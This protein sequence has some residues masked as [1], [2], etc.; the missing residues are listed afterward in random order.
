MRILH[1]SNNYTPYAGGLVSSLNALLPGL[2]EAGHT[3]MLIV[4][5]FVKEHNDPSFVRRI[6]AFIRFSYYN[7]PCSLFLRPSAHIDTLV[8]QF[9]P[10]IIHVHHP[11]LLGFIGGKIARRYNIPCVFT[12]HTMYDQYAHYVPLPKMLT[13]PCIKYSVLGFCQNV[14]QTIIA[15]SVGIR[16]WL[17][18]HAVK[19][20]IFVVPSPIQ[21]HF[22]QNK[23]NLCDDR[24]R[25]LYVG[26]FT[27]EKNVQALIDLCYNLDST[28]FHLTLVGFGID[29]DFLRRRSMGLSEGMISFVI[30]PTLEQLLKIYRESDLFLFPSK[31]DTQGIV[32]AEAMAAGLPIIAFDGP[33]QRDAI[34]MAENGFIVENLIDMKNT[35][36]LL[37][38][39]RSLLAQYSSKARERALFFQRKRIIRCLEEV[40]DLVKNNR[41][42]TPF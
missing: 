2:E 30:R 29:E 7:N 19:T 21:D 3:V 27:P 15:P 28:K 9:K 16:Q 6:P 34:V 26:R 20:P 33:G 42:N 8:K 1:I 10:D 31:T 37:C 12:Y 4:P 35:I 24:F 5:Q 23:K 17:E 38:E 40:Y 36:E 25:L 18:N 13:V 41:E 11:F 32:L 39:N 14:V 22:F